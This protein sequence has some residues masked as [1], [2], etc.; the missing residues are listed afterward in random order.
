MSVLRR[1][2]ICLALAIAAGLTA[3]G[4][5]GTARPATGVETL[6]YTTPAITVPGYGVVTQP[7]LT[8]SPR[9]DGY[10]VGLK[11]EVVDAKGRV[12]G[13]R[14]VMLHH[15]VIGKLGVPDATCGGSTQRFYAEGEERTQMRLPPG[16]GYPNKG[17]DHW[18]LLYML[19]NHKPQ[20]LV[21]YIRYTV[22]YVTGETL[23]PVQPVWLDV[24]NCTGLDPSFD[25]P[26]TGKR[27]SAYVRTM[28]WTS[29]TSGRIVAG[30]GHL[31]GGG[32][33]LEL[34]NVT[35]GTEPFV[36]EPTWGGYVPHPILHEPGPTHMSQ[37]TSEEGIP[38]AAGQ[39]LRLTAV[40]DNGQPHTRTMGIMLL[41]VAPGPVTGCQ[42][43]PKLDIDLGHP[44]YP[45]FFTFP[46]PVTPKGPV[47]RGVTSS[48]VVDDAF[49]HPLVSIRLG[50]TFTWTF[51]GSVL[52]DVTL[53][54]GPVGFSSPWTLD[55]TF[56]HRF[57]RPGV[58]KLFCSLH[59]AQMSQII[60]VR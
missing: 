51:Q 2:R 35:C 56:T 10:V 17:T 5:P 24:R 28:D 46:L 57:T 3:L 45:P 50:T 31:H 48:N 20:T 38:V 30:G 33:R 59:P 34:H 58:Y 52:H 41:Y 13:R 6:V 23:K 27:F 25:V 18:Y 36:S 8:Q 11:A 7:I 60:V 43:D 29:P 9:D 21:G 42:P 14:K 44:S 4:S 37:F 47:A 26:G 1:V 54:S 15:I 39:T 40:Y 32:I 22:T 16:Y 55:G 12:Q 19:M 49:Q 53:V